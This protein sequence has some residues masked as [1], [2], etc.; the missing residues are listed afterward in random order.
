ME[1]AEKKAEERKEAK[2]TEEVAKPLNINS[3]EELT[4]KQGVFDTL[5]P[6]FIFSEYLMQY[7]V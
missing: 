4:S 6:P 1:V 5:S 3:N 2:K 7:Q